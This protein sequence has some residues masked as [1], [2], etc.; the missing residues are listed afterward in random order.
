MVAWP[1]AAQV[2]QAKQ[3]ELTAVNK[4][5][6]SIEAELQNARKRGQAEQLRVT[7]GLLAEAKKE[8]QRSAAQLAES[9]AIAPELLAELKRIEK[10]ID[11]LRINIAA[12]K[13]TAKLES[14]PACSVTVQRGT[15]EPEIITLSPI[16]RF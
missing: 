3:T 6:E 16:S 15:G 7:H 9:K 10:E 12:Q 1:G 5:L 2:I 11:R 8:W 4:D 13:L 14:A